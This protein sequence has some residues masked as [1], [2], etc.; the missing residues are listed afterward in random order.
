MSD[1]RAPL[2][3]LVTGAGGM[4]AHDLV[5]VLRRAGHV[6]TALGRADLDVTD[7]AQCLAGVSGHDLVVNTAAYTAVDAA[8]TDE[9]VAFAVNAVGAANLAQGGVQRRRASRAGLDRLRLR[10]RRDRAVCR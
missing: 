8:E 2:R 7:P 3:V 9:A 5:P 4:L 10:R 6:V 1:H